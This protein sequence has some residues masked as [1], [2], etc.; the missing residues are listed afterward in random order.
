MRNEPLSWRVILLGDVSLCTLAQQAGLF[1][2][3]ASLTTTTLAELELCLNSSATPNLH[4]VREGN[5]G[6]G[7]LGER[8]VVVL[9][10]YLN[11]D[12]LLK[13]DELCAQT[14][15]YWTQFHLEQGLGWL[16]PAI[17]PGRTASYQDVLSRRL[18]AA[19]DL[20]LH[21]TL[22]TPPFNLGKPDLLP[23]IELVWLLAIF[24]TQVTR[25]LAGQP[26]RLLS[27]ELSAN[28]LTLE[29][30]P[31]PVL[32]LP[33]RALD[34]PLQMS[35]AMDTG[36]LLN[37]RSGLVLQLEGV[38]HHASVP[39]GLH[40][41]QAH[42][43]Q[44]NRYDMAWHNVTTSLG[45]SFESEQVSR[46]AAVGEAVERYC[47][48]YPYHRN[49]CKATYHEIMRRGEHAVAP[50]RLVLF[51]EQIYRTPGCPFVPFTRELP[52]YWL[53]G[54]SLTQNRPAWLPLTLVYADW[55][56][57]QFP[58]QPVT[59][60][61]HYPGVAAGETLEQAIVSGIEELIERDSM[62]IWWLNR[63]PLPAVELPPELAAIWRG[64]PEELGQR[65][66]AI[67]LQNEFAIPVMAGVV[68]N[69][70]EQLLNIGFACRPDA[71]TATR[72]AWAEALTLQ[73]RS[74][75]LNQPDSLVRQEFDPAS[76]KPWR[77]DRAYLDDYRS[78]FR[79]VIHGAAQEQIFLDPRA[80]EQVRP[81]VD[82]PAMLTFGDLPK[83]PNR[84]LSTYRERIE[85][86]GYE[87]FYIDLTTSDVAQ[88]G[89]RV[90]RVIIPGL[91]PDFPAAFP[92][93]GLGRIQNR[94]IHL[95]WRSKPLTEEELNYLPMP[96]S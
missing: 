60:D 85:G 65:A 87:I 52:V 7:N 75:D 17:I 31:Y 56:T 40:T 61:S 57:E 76:L 96:H 34:G 84:A 30:R 81:W 83:L 32:P 26:C 15:T 69:R 62:M 14:N 89:L 36:L 82:T 71:L 39:D 48:N 44:M 20:A 28:P 5:V 59:H 6:K 10:E 80:I 94:P 23:R 4:S 93:T 88:T 1:D 13:V 49:P 2:Q 72:K 54:F 46:A 78:D 45:S 37:Q 53:R 33:M 12:F 73:E 91:V 16:G 8:V 9:Q 70:V 79:D 19:A 58:D 47:L 51:S 22:A 43:A 95:G 27:V 41:V 29:L 18:C 35:A 50:E 55:P 74:R 86:A 3:F 11:G 24:F 66:W 77:R 21:S 67:Y 92:H 68:E 64:R 38:T 90:V 25:W 63:Q 42:L